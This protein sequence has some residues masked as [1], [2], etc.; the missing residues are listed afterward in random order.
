MTSLCSSSSIRRLT[1]WMR[2]PA[3]R[4]WTSD[5]AGLTLTEVL[6]TLVVVALVL[7]IVTNVMAESDKVY[8][9]QSQSVD[10]RNN[11][12]AGMDMMARLIRQAVFLDPDPDG[13]NLL[14]SIHVRADWNP[15]DGDQLDA[16]EDVTFTVV[17]GTLFKQE[18]ADA[19]PVPFADRIQSVTFTYFD[20]LDV[21][22]ATPWA[23]NMNRLSRINIA[24]ATTPLTNGWPGRTYATSV[25]VRRVE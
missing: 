5:D 16:Y 25:S 23:F 1:D 10:G 19:G 15:Y 17:G 13:N 4:C 3:R 14:D 21:P 2:R 11:A 6:V 7:G 22:V 12:E 8:R 18:P 9:T 24:V 20:V